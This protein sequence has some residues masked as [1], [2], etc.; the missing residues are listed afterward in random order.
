MPD[1]ILHKIIDS[2]DA[3]MPLL[4]LCSYLLLWKK[5]GKQE[6][7]L[8]IYLIINILFGV[9]TNVMGFYHINNLL[10]YHFYTL[11]EQWFVS[12][13]L[14]SKITRKKSSRIYFSMNIG[15]TIFW[16]IDIALWEPLNTFNS[17]TAVI[18]DLIL[19][20][21][22]MYYILDLVKKDE[23]LYFQ[24][25]PSFW[26]INGF[27]IYSALSM[28]IFAIYNYYIIMNIPAEGEKVFNLMHIS[29]PVKYI[30]ISIGLL[31]YRNRTKN[32]PQNIPVA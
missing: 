1:A 9:V 26:I 7:M 31:C 29:V 3:Y 15:F 14:I 16:I 24:K 18:S 2:D 19:L 12:W 30:L 28:L 25:L 27:L 32:I 23:V 6:A 20:F 10:L 5:I 17:N 13:Y 8:L 11:F 4:A 21:L 22:C